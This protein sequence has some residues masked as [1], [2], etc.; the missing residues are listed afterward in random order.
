MSVYNQTPYNLKVAGTRDIGSFSESIED[1]DWRGNGSDILMSYL[2]LSSKNYPN[3]KLEFP[4]AQ[5]S[6]SNQDMMWNLVIKYSYKKSKPHKS[7]ITFPGGEEYYFKFLQ[8]AIQKNL[9]SYSIGSSPSNK[10]SSKSS[11]GQSN[12]SSYKSKSSPSNKSSYKSSSGQ[13]NKSSQKTRKKGLRKYLF[14]VS[15]LFIGSSKSGHYNML[16]YDVLRKKVIRIEPYGKSY[17]TDDLEDILDSQLQVKFIAHGFKVDIVSPSRFM[18]NRSFQWIEEIKELKRGIGV[19]RPNDPGGMCGVWSTFIAHQIFKYPEYSLRK[20]L[21]KIKR[22]I[23]G[24]VA[25]RDFIRNL[26][27]HY[28][29]VGKRLIDSKSKTS[30]KYTSVTQ[31]SES[32]LRIKQSLTTNK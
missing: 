18:E 14:I 13:S 31:V 22:K 6:S 32:L 17:S 26:S 16:I 9:P 2:Y 29:R 4:H 20:L 11:S 30:N 1:T 27:Q 12:K 10:L 28:L 3:V 15:G 25:L 7:K 21:K 8:Q 19:E 5:L 23:E 24:E